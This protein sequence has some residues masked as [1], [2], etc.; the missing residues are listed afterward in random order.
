[1]RKSRKKIIHKSDCDNQDY[2]LAKAKK[3]KVIKYNKNF[4]KVKYRY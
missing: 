2:Y 4:L 3:K 1:M